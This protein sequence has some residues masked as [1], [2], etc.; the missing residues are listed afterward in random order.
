[1]IFKGADKTLEIKNGI[2]TIQSHIYK[3]QKSI[4]IKS[5]ASV[6]LFPATWYSAGLLKVNILGS[7]ESDKNIRTQG[8]FSRMKDDN[9]VSFR[10]GIQAQAMLMHDELLKIITT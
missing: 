5:I 8:I 1:M 4:P 7:T 9:T 6:E 3:T 10:K 2:L